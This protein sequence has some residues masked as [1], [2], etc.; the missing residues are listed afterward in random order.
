MTATAAA[1]GHTKPLAGPIDQEKNESC[2]AMGPIAYGFD[3]PGGDGRIVAMM[4][5]NNSGPCTAAT[6]R[7]PGCR[8]EDCA[9]SCC[10]DPSCNAWVHAAAEGCA[11]NKGK[12]GAVDVCCWR[13]VRETQLQNM[14]KENHPQRYNPTISTGVV[15]GHAT[16]SPPAP[17]PPSP[18]CGAP[19]PQG[20]GCHCGPDGVCPRAPPVVKRGHALYSTLVY[21][22]VWPTNQTLVPSKG[23]TRYGSSDK[24]GD[25]SSADVEGEI[26]HTTA[27]V[28]DALE[29][30]ATLRAQG[31]LTQEEFTQAKRRALLG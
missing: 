2:Y 28:V 19:S 26:E 10:D 18:P 17:S 8:P 21:Y 22:Y 14:T 31:A 3:R 11:R 23:K 25:S 16:R 15:S 5:A 27:G 20:T 1:R 7:A 30:L 24:H 13:K 12:G 29:R 9:R 6:I 4:L